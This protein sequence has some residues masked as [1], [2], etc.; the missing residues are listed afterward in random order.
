MWAH[1]SSEWLCLKYGASLSLLGKE[2][3]S[4]YPFTIGQR[5]AP[6]P[7]S[8]PFTIGSRGIPPLLLGKE[9]PPPYY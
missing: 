3:P 1:W 5:G 8:L 2:V 9:V 4:L 7:P 6:P